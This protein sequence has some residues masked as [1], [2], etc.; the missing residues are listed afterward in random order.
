VD[1]ERLR[2]LVDAA[3]DEDPL[4]ALAGAAELRREAERVQAVAVRRARAVGLSWA[5]IA[6][7]LQVS[8]QAAHR[9]YRGRTFGVGADA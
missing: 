4:R 8:K 2:M 9:K 7:A 5:E 1:V 3:D 6:A